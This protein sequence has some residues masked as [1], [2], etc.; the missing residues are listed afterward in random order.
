MRPFDGRRILLVVT[1][2]IAAYK[3]A[4]LTRRLIEVGARVDVVLTRD[5]QRFIGR[6]TFEGLTGRPVYADLWDRPMA[7]LDL[8][9]AAD[10]AVVAPATADFLFR[11]AHGAAGDLASA[12]L[13]AADCPLVVC[14][15][16][17]T[18]MWEHPA[19]RRNVERLR[20]RG[21]HQVGPADGALAE[22]EEGPGRMAE[23][24]EIVAALGR[25][26]ERPTLAG[27]RVVVTAGPTRAPLDPVRFL[28][29]RSSGRMGFALA[30]SA[31]RR[32]ADVVV[33][34][35]PGAAPRPRGPV[36]REV[37]TASQMKAALEEEL[38]T[39]SVLL[40]AAAVSD[41][42]RP[43]PAREKI[44]KEGSD[45]LTVELARSVDL[46]E[47]TAELRRE[48]GILTLG[49]ALETESPIENATRKMEAKGLDY[50]AVNRADE[51]DA[52]FEAETNRVTLMDR[53]GD[54]ESLP[55]LLKE[56]VA[57]RLLDRMEEKLVD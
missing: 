49:F 36:V 1:G 26:L 38:A 9:R 11:L 55:L 51:P 54:V 32:G 43:E 25:L 41:Y 40:M 39:A 23:P 12:T 31:W 22:G 2:G 30:C 47:S 33:I 44:K 20:E 18:R 6:T 56:E 52:G 3:S 48:R 5:A 42:E 35:G 53:W 45:L 15:A 19:T 10:A 13:L 29:N 27:R 37:E 17:N 46:L 8:G 7:H 16:M 50:V 21:V 34:T 14:P 4:Y 57:D 24:E 28:S